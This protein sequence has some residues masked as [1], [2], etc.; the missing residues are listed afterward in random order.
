MEGEK[1]KKEKRVP[2]PSPSPLSSE[3]DLNFLSR[4]E[5]EKVAVASASPEDS[6]VPSRGQIGYCITLGK[7][8][9]MPL[10]DMYIR[11]GGPP[12]RPPQ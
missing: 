1:G 11:R 6:A 3:C 12:S 4:S 7:S 5:E 2:Y 9:G 8:S 10:G